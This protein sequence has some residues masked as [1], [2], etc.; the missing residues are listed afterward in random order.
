[1]EISNR[2][3]RQEI[4]DLNVVVQE[5]MQL[6]RRSAIGSLP[7]EPT[8]VPV[9]IPVPRQRHGLGP[10]HGSG[11]VPGAEQVPGQG[12]MSDPDHFR[13]DSGQGN[14]QGGSQ[15]YPNDFTGPRMRRPGGL[16]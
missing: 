10:G 14:R 7:L 2:A 15:G 4:H 5:V 3:N 6:L 13:M 12:Q 9:P 16:R 1:V 8:H 11:M